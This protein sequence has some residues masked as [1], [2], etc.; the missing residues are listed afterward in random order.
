MWMREILHCTSVPKGHIYQVNFS[1][2]LPQILLRLDTVIALYS[3]IEREQPTMS[4]CQQNGDLSFANSK[5][6]WRQ[7]ILFCRLTIKQ[8]DIRSK[9]LPQDRRFPSRPS[10]LTPPCKD[11]YSVYMTAITCDC[12]FI[13]TAVRTKAMIL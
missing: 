2:A 3:V 7:L 9:F 8:L 5:L 11:P 13:A 1:R 10:P 12:D 4:G 6:Q